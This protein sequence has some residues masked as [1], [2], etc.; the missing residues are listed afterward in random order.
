MISDLKKRVIALQAG[1][2][3][4]GEDAGPEPGVKVAVL[5]E[6]LR[7][8]RDEKEKHCKML[9]N[10]YD[11]ELARL[12]SMYNQDIRDIEEELDMLRVRVERC[13][14]GDGDKLDVE[15]KKLQRVLTLT[16]QRVHD[17][18]V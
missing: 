15:A 9:Q 13:I 12:S 18:S 2:D 6:S 3:R 10:N 4:A 17:K 11:V 14:T 7:L 16:K 1:L 8:E 5:E